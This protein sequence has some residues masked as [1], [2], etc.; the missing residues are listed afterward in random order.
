[1][2]SNLLKS[3]HCRYSNEP[4]GEINPKKKILEKLKPDMKT[5]ASRAFSLPIFYQIMES[6]AI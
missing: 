1:M 2:L 4:L 3:Y 5:D 6:P